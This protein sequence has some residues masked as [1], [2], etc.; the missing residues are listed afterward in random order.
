MNK[1]YIAGA[2]SRGRTLR[3]YLEYLYQ[4]IVVE[5]FLVDDMEGN[6]SM[7]D[8]VPVKLIEAGLNENYPVYLGTRGTNHPKLTRELKEAGMKE[9]IPVTAELDMKL[10]NEYVRKYLQQEGRTFL[11]IDDLDTKG[12]KK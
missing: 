6:P 2:H 8:G 9:I 5:A 4:D 3:I 12:M 10:R 7:A 11:L 1:V